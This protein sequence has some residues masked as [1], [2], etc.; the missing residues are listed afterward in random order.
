MI[1]ADTGGILAY[2][3]EDEPDHD[4]VVDVVSRTTEEL[5]VSPFVVAEVDFMVM[6]KFG[7]DKEVEFLEDVAIGRWT[8]APWSN[9][10]IRAALTVVR[11]YGDFKLGVADASNVVLAHRYDTNRILTLD[12]RHFRKVT[13]TSG[14]AFTLLPSDTE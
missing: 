3:D 12:H 10:D 5:I 1:I 9:D 4:S 6:K 13:T 2:V 7:I 14:D 8:L 11:K